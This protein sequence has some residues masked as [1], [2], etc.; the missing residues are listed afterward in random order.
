LSPSFLDFWQEFSDKVVE[1]AFYVFWGNF[2]GN[3]ISG[4]NVIIFG[5]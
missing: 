1:T 5:L 3:F 4:K 2:E